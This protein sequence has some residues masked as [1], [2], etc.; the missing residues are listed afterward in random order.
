MTVYLWHEIALILA[1]PLIDRFRKAP[2]FEAYLPLESQWFL[3][4]VGWVLIGA[5][6]LMCAWV[7][8]VAARRRP[9]LLP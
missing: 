7:E 9:R 8:D 6:V 1:V 5:F 2:S 4:A 3:F